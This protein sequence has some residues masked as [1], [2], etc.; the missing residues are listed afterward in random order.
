MNGQARCEANG[1]RILEVF[2]AICLG[3]IVGGGIRGILGDHDIDAT[4][5]QRDE[6]RRRG[7][8]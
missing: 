5:R 8:M 2:K 6:V 3:F 7:A 4:G 1:R